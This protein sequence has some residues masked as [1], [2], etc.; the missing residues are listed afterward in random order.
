M[1]IVKNTCF[2]GFG[3][4]EKAQERLI[5]LGVR[6]FESIEALNVAKSRD[7]L[8]DVWIVRNEE[9]SYLGKYCDD[10]ND[11]KYRTIPSLIQVVEELGKDAD[12]RH[13]SLEIVEIPDGMDYEIDDYDGVETISEPHRSW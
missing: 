6:F 12:G 13:A 9:G 8:D 11:Y 1:K 3:L 2:G 4:S 5:E 10:F 7:G